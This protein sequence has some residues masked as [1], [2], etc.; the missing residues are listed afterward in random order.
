MIRSNC[1]YG[2]SHLSTYPII[3]VHYVFHHQVEDVVY[4]FEVY[5]CL[6]E[7]L[8]RV[9][10]ANMEQVAQWRRA[11]D[12]LSPAVTTQTLVGIYKLFTPTSVEVERDFKCA[13]YCCVCIL[14]LYTYLNT[15]P[16]I[17]CSR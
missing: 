12:V 11:T 17:G 7:V 8:Q 9:A 13:F 4:H 2:Y 15:H 10:L 3:S 5:V 1:T 6:E 16:K 14:T